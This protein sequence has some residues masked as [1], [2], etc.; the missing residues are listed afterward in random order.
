MRQ[1]NERRCETCGGMYEGTECPN[2]CH[3]IVYALRRAATAL[4]AAS[5]A[6]SKLDEGTGYPPHIAA[7]D[8]ARA[9]E[10]AM[11]ALRLHDTR[12]RAR[13]HIREDAAILEALGDG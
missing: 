12:T 4:R 2:G 10:H 1:R 8:A 7:A 9:Q 5:V 11:A 13:R 3:G 6:F